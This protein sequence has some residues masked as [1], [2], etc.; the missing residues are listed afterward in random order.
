MQMSKGFI[1]FLF[2]NVWRNYISK[3]FQLTLAFVPISKNETKLYL[4]SYF[5][6]PNFPIAR[7]LAG[8]FLNF[9]NRIILNQDKAVVLSQNPQSIFEDDIESELLYPSDK[10]IAFYRD[11][12]KQ[13]R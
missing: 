2:P 6:N 7:E 13:A 11:S 8:V 12:F 9:T 10:A 4:R 3:S 1:E 5:K